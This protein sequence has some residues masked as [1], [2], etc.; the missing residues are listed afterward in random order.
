MKEVNVK[1]QIQHLVE[2]LKA[3]TR[4]LTSRRYDEVGGDHH[5]FFIRFLENFF[6]NKDGRVEKL[7]ENSK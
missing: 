7:I 6:K 4:N 1:I 3:A 2:F 5:N